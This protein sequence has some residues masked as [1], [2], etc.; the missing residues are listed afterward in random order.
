MNLRN[1]PTLTMFSHLDDAHKNLEILQ[2]DEV[3]TWF[4]TQMVKAKRFQPLAVLNEKLKKLDVFEDDEVY[5]HNVVSETTTTTTVTQQNIPLPPPRPAPEI[6]VTRDHWQHHTSNGTCSDP[7]CDRRLGNTNGNINCRKCGKLFCEEH[8]MYQIKLSRT[9][10][11]EP[12]QGV[13]SR[14]CETCYKSRDGYNDHAGR[15]CFSLIVQD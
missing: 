2:Q 11:H 1:K 13:W 10:Q 14:V 12:L 9:A 3:K 7:L 5:R 8:T 15:S 6:V 4:K